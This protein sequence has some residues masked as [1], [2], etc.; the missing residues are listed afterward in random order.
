M[1]DKVD[2]TTGQPTKK[3]EVTSLGLMTDTDPICET[4]WNFIIVS[5]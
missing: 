2:P 1:T 5:V 3:G 4:G